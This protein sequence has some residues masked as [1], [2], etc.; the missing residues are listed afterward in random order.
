MLQ[1][2]QY[3]H[4]TTELLESSLQNVL[5]GNE[6]ISSCFP[7]PLILRVSF[8]FLFSK[9]QRGNELLLDSMATV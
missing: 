9:G 8:K 5:S 2:P 7:V 4:K 1:T 6:F 3:I